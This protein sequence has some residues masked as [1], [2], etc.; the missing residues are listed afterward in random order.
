[1]KVLR[2]LVAIILALAAS[3]LLVAVALNLANVVG[4]KFLHAPISSAEE[5]MAFL[6][7]STVFLGNSAVGW[8]GRQIRMDVIL[9]MLPPGW[10]RAFD[11]VADLAVIVVSVVVIVGGWPAIQMLIDFDQRSEAADIPLYLPQALV[12]I[13]LGLNA[14]LVAARLIVG[15]D[16]R[17]TDDAPPE[18]I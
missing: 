8:R 15:R 1:M 12:P 10:P 16:P 18:A 6:L 7:V 2:A 4:R 14:I 3:S 13:G 9:H 5:I 11:I 17:D